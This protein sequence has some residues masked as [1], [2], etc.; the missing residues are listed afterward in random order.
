MSELQKTDQAIFNLIQQEKT[1]QDTSIRLIP[2]E[3]YTSPAVMEATGSALTNKYSEGYSNKRYYEGQEY[4]D[5]IEQLAIDRAKS[6]FGAYG[7]NVQAL[8]G[9]PAN[10]AALLA[11]VKPSEKIMGLA[12]PHGGHLTHGWKV[13]ATGIY[14]DAIQYTLDPETY[15]LNYDQIRDM[16]LKERPKLI[17]TGA[18][19]YPRLIDFKIFREIADE[20]GAKLLVDMA[21]IAGLVAGGVHPSPVPHAHVITSTTHK[22]LRGPRGGLILMAKGFVNKIN[23][24]VFPG[25]QGGPHN[26]TT[27]AIAVALKEAATPQF[28]TYAKQVVE[29]ASVLAE[30]LLAD[31]FN[32]VT[33]GTDTHLILMDLTNKG[34]TGKQFA[35]ALN[36]VN[37]ESNA[38]TV[39]FDTRS[40]FDP[41]GLRIG[42]PAVTTKGMGPSEMKLIA[43]WINQVS[44]HINDDQFLDKLSAEVAAFSSEFSLKF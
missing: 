27:A 41:S 29:N 42:T 26:H 21:H 35:S 9:A 36:R 19:A 33:G 40:P 39:P 14:Y 1:R 10:L 3:N 5:Q 28:K 44:H 11:M 30:Q 17:I 16:A 24:A 23:K 34:I 43:S 6:L 22:T 18:S 25:L 20:V 13:S 38:N 15:R 4:I 2:S 7:A 12:L 32:L 37:I 8:S 31:G